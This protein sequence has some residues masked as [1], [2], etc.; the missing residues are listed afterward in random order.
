MLGFSSS[1]LRK[2]DAECVCVWV[3]CVFFGYPFW[4]WFKRKSKGPLPFVS[5]LTRMLQVSLAVISGSSERHMV[6]VSQAV[7]GTGLCFVECSKGLQL[8]FAK[9]QGVSKFASKRGAKEYQEVCADMVAR[10][11]SFADM[12]VAHRPPPPC[13]GT[14][15]MSM[16]SS[17]FL[18]C[19]AI[20]MWCRLALLHISN[21]V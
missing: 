3:C 7:R 21:V 6:S 4:V 15:W 11:H 16:T 18:D 10:T 2:K 14:P 20:G 9:E 19:H 1:V 13:R 8:F 12:G 17:S 5:P